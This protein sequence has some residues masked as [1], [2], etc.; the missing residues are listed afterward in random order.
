MSG[1]HVYTGSPIT[2]AVSVTWNNTPLTKDTDYTLAYTDNTNAGTATVTVTGTGNYTGTKTATFTIEKATPTPTTPTG[3][4]ATYG[5]TL[6]NVKLP[7]GW[8]WDSPNTSVGDVGE[9]EFSA[10]YTKDNSG[11]Y[12]EVK[13]NLTVK[14]NPAPYKITLT[15]QADSP[16]QITLDKAV[17]EPG[18]TGTTVTYGYNNTNSVPGRWQTER[19]FSGLTADTTYYFFAKAEDSS[20]YAKN[21][22]PGS[23]DHHPRKGR[24]QN[25]DYC[26]ARQ[27]VLHQR[28]DTGF[29]RF[30]GTG[31]LQR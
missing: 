20:N 28:A 7:A 17:V 31:V 15:G 29:E 10:T 24:E 6:A 5:Q 3:L 12:N 21:H 18:N 25:R 23:S 8:A 19:V 14:V 1:N 13:Q 16:T 22:Q 2:P 27:P 4:T 9:K 26:P 30:V 11:N